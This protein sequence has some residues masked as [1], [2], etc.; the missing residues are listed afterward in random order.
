MKVLVVDDEAS[1]RRAH[2]RL[3]RSL[4]H[5]VFE[6]EDPQDARRMMNHGLKPDVIISDWNM[7]RMTGGMFCSILRA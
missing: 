3:I 2:S 4:G 1:V 7:P 5:E 6:A